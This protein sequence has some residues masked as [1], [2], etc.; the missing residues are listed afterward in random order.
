MI[1]GKI[2]CTRGSKLK[3][4][5]KVRMKERSAIKRIQD[6]EMDDGMK[7]LMQQDFKESD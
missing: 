5:R 3:T 2:R 1:Q 4:S 6:R 7:Q